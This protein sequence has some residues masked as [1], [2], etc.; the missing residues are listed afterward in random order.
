MKSNERPRVPKETQ[1]MRYRVEIER[2]GIFIPSHFFTLGTYRWLWLAR[3]IGR[4]YVWHQPYRAAHI[5][6]FLP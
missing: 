2:G 3:L 6:S 1:A 4:L 5:Y